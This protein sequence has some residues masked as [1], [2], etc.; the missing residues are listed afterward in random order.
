MDDGTS[1]CKNCNHTN[2]QGTASSRIIISSQDFVV[3]VV[4]FWSN[5]TQNKAQKGKTEDA[6]VVEIVHPV[7]TR[8]PGESYRR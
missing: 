4:L 7:F 3:V 2:R 6:T 5:L 8:M 1:R